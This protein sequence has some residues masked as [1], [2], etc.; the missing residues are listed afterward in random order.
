M[1]KKEEKYAHF[2]IDQKALRR[3]SALSL[4]TFPKS[5]AINNH[6]SLETSFRPQLQVH[7]HS[8]KTETR[9]LKTLSEHPIFIH[10]SHINSGIES[11][12]SG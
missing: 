1:K 7:H 12:T 6:A 9:P 3:R 11:F 10:K 5:T 4:A 2:M 8:W